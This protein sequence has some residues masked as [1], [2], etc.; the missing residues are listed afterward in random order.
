M[1]P[2]VT[3]PA[4]PLLAEKQRAALISLLADDDPAIYQI[5]RGKLLTYGQAAGH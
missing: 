5:V 4:P 1:E 2:A 3:S